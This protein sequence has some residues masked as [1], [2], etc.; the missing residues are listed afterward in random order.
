MPKSLGRENLVVRQGLEP[1]RYSDLE[2]SRAYKAHPHTRATDINLVRSV[3]VEPTKPTFSTSCVCLFRHERISGLPERIRTSDAA[4][5]RRGCVHHQGESGAPSRI[6]THVVGLEGRLPVRRPGLIWSG[7]RESNPT[8]ASLAT[9]PHTMCIR[10]L[11]RVAGIA[12]AASWFRARSS[13][14]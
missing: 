11:V 12:P 4:H 9:I 3:G 2:L 13:D 14:C 5:R 6:R 1:C 8:A 7:H 10:E